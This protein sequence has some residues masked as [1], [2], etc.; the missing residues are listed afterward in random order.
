MSRARVRE[1]GIRG[2]VDVDEKEVD[3]NCSGTG[4]GRRGI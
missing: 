2:S 1:D 4:A 3:D